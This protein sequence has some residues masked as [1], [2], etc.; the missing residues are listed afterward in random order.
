M[1]SGGMGLKPEPQENMLPDD[2][3]QSD[4][5]FN[6]ISRLNNEL[7]N[8]ERRT[9]KQI[10]D[11]QKAIAA[12]QLVEDEL[13]EAVQRYKSIIDGTQAGTWDWNIETGESE[14]SELWARI[15]G[16]TL[17]ELRP[18]TSKTWEGLRHPDDLALCDSL[19]KRHLSGELPYYD[20]EYRMRHK[21]GNPLKMYGTHTDISER[22]KAEEELQQ[23]ILINKNLL[24]ELQHRA[25]NSFNMILSLIEIEQ[26]PAASVETSSSLEELRGRVLSL[27]ELYDL[28]YVSGSSSEVALDDYF[29]KVTAAMRMMTRG[30]SIEE[31][32]E[33]LVVPISKA[34]PLGLILTELLT[35]SIKYAFP[36]GGPGT[37]S[38]SL[39]TAAVGFT[40]SVIDDGVGLPKDFA[41]ARSSGSGFHLI[42]G[43]AK[44]I[45]G[46]LVISPQEKGSCFLLTVPSA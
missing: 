1:W 40:L 46:A 33:R 19:L 42:A 39:H 37:I 26:R 14:P 17:E 45:G 16:Y 21:D 23:T 10:V 36:G 25:K 9:A 27:A 5:I 43:L 3:P 20:C 8:A 34:A 31:S 13:K 4:A 6:E 44:Q 12:R 2:I 29:R 11:L 22:K 15:V 32:L 24:R 41:L 7:I 38:V 18:F 30:P 28:L 35:N